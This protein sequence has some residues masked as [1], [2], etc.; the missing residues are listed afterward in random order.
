MT[1]SNDQRSRGRLNLARA[2]EKFAEWDQTAVGQRT[3]FMFARLANVDKVNWFSRCQLAL[4]FAYVD[5]L[6]QRCTYLSSAW[7]ALQILK[8]NDASVRLMAQHVEHVRINT[9]FDM[10]YGTIDE[11]RVDAAGMGP[12]ERK[13]TVAPFGIALR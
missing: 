12:A 13:A 5:L 6:D 7:K 11:N 9:K 2:L 10:M 4:Q 3:R 8:L 1:I